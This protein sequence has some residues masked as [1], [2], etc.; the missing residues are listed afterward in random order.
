MSLLSRSKLYVAGLTAAVALGACGGSPGDPSFTLSGTVATGAAVAHA[1]VTIKGSTG[2]S[3][4]TETAI[5]SGVDGSYTCTLKAGEAAPFFIVATDPSGNTAPLV[6]IATQMPEAGTSSVVNVTTLTTAIVGQLNG[7]DALGV[8]AKP[9]LYVAA[10]LELIKQNVAAQ[11]KSLV[12]RVDANMVN[13]DPFSTP[14][15]ASTASATGN[16]ADQILDAIKIT[17]TSDGK[18]AI[19]TI[20]D[21]TPKVLAT[22][23]SKGDTVMLDVSVADI[24]RA[25]QVVAKAFTD[26]FALSKAERV[27]LDSNQFISN[28]HPTCAAILSQGN[29]AA[30][31]PVFKANGR[32][33][34]YVLYHYLL[35]DA[36]TGVRFGVPEI[37][38]LYPAD[39]NVTRDRAVLNIKYVDSKGYPG[40]LITTALNVPNTA[41]AGHPS[42]WWLTGNQSNYD[43][44]IFPT[45]WRDEY[46]GAP[47]GSFFKNGLSPH[48]NAKTTGSDA[49]PLASTYDSVL[50]TGDG[51]P[52]TGLWYVRTSTSI[53]LMNISSVRGAPP[54]P[55]A[56]LTPVSAGAVSFWM[57][58]TEGLTGA[59]ATR[60]GEN[61]AENN[62]AHAN[63]G[64]Y[65]GVDGTVP[66]KG[67]VYTFQL[68]KNT[69]LVATETRL[70]L[71]DLP[72]AKDGYRTYWH[73]IGSH[74]QAAL[75][76]TNTA[77]NGELSSL[78]VDWVANPRAEVIRYLW[79]SQND[80][81]GDNGTAFTPGVESVLAT[82]T[83]GTKFTSLIS[84]S[85]NQAPYGGYREIGLSYWTRDGSVKSA[86]YVYRP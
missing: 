13:Y 10:D 41:T 82:P 50:V 6:S 68:F 60:L 53:Y 46:F 58:R 48:I 43:L 14:I 17:L 19:A 70:L 52:S 45:A 29:A 79:V 47:S 8:V 12:N 21:P 40:N 75:D 63:D 36:L 67:S 24:S 2:N 5:S 65:N 16:N 74:T 35:S 54:Q 64:S 33:A 28:L 61:L 57:S 78:L 73:G 81:S 69:A 77:L 23:E 4:C 7:G 18:A 42:N 76:K 20:S 49:A 30:G 32:S 83:N 44:D 34:P 15:K 25:A 84:G 66:K 3:S 71:G 26:C 38:A 80:G 31:I 86:S 59:S 85:Q 22:K 9:G 56:N 51:L 39:A 1:V 27:T 37:M 55:V 11:L 62:W 72:A